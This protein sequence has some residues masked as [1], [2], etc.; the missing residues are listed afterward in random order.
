MSDLADAATRAAI[1]AVLKAR[2]AEAYELARE[3]CA[4]QLDVGDRK[5]GRLGETKIGTA[6]LVTGRTTARVT[7]E[8]ALIKWVA[9]N[10]PDEI[11]EAVR[12]AYVNKLLTDAKTYGDAVDV[13]TGELIP[14]ITV[15]AGN[16]YVRVESAQDAAETITAQWAEAA[17][18]VPELPG[19]SDV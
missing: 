13:T 2:V 1:L 19:G 11:T 10:H 15:S 6:S 3:A 9:T 16:P 7:D 5:A 18:Y 8:T 14:G 17:R 12:T 4:E